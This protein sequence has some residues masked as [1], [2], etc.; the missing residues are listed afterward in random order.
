L[1]FN[2]EILNNLLFFPTF[3]LFAF[4]FC[5]LAAKRRDF[6]LLSQHRQ[7]LFENFFEEDF[8]STQRALQPASGFAACFANLFS[9]AVVSDCVAL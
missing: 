6:D 2:F 4:A 3:K 7:A 9:P 5:S 8:F 1:K